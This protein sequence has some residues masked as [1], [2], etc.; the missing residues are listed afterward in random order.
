M[1]MAPIAM[2]FLRNK[3]ILP[4]IWSSALC[5]HRDRIDCSEI[6]RIGLKDEKVE[7]GRLKIAVITAQL[8][9]DARAYTDKELEAMLRIY[10][11][12]KDIPLCEKIEK[13]KVESQ[14]R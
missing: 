4:W 13:V 10:L 2:A 7:G 12:P 11:S 3:W 1:E 6:Q 8:S 5:N 9:P 14:G